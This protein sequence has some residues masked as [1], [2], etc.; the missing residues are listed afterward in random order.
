MDKNL[1]RKKILELRCN[2]KD[3]EKI[4]W[5]QLIFASLVKSDFFIKA[6][7]IFIYVSYKNEVDTKK[8]IQYSLK[9]K[10]EIYVP[11][12][13]LN[14]KNMKAIKINSL[15]E[16]IVDNYGILEPKYVDKNNI[17]DNFDLIIMPGVA[18]DRCGN[19]IGYG[20][21]Y[22]DK[23]ISKLNYNVLKIALAYH[24][25]ITDSIKAECHDINVD[26]IITNKS[27]AVMNGIY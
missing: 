7:K 3:E 27:R 5:D 21:G 12:T 11:K 14:E 18:F 8:I 15:D 24:F 19:R 6:K 4:E 16:L 2:I 9:N 25:Q 23:Y 26:Y 1:V 20:G 10:K 17:G 13:Y 22:Y